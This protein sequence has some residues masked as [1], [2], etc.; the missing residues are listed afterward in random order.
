MSRRDAF[1][2]RRM[3]RRTAGGG[4]CPARTRLTRSLP[5]ATA[6]V[7]PMPLKLVTH[8]SY[9]K[10]GTHRRLDMPLLTEWDK[11]STVTGVNIRDQEPP[12]LAVPLSL[13]GSEVLTFDVGGPSGWAAFHSP[14]ASR[15]G[16]TLQLRFGPETMDPRAA[17]QVRELHVAADPRG[18]AFSSPL[19]RTLPFSR[20][21]AAVNR[22]VVREQL[23]PLMPAANMIES[24]SFGSGLI[25]WTF[26]PLE[27]VVA[28]QPILALTVPSDRRKPDEFY[29]LVADTYLAQATLSNR[30]AQD[31][32]EANTVPVSTVHRWLKEARNRGVL[33]LPQ[34]GD[35][36]GRDGERR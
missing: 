23:R 33:R 32:A 10:G 9:V 30:A 8:V 34:Q 4:S 18:A 13:D 16:L 22:E 11:G 29:A 19:L 15:A 27:P 28:N 20:M 26:K 6:V 25:A 2:R 14:E 1:A 24:A 5:S 21:V 31:L 36:R 35:L 7:D 3:L 12:P 17:L